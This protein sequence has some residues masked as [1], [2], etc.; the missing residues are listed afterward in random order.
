M[1]REMKRTHPEAFVF[2]GGVTSSYFAQEILAEFPFIDA[3]VLGHGEGVVRQLLATLATGGDPKEV[4]N[5]ALNIDGEAIETRGIPFAPG[6]LPD[7]NELPKPPLIIIFK[8]FGNK[9]FGTKFGTA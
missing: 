6:V 8:N 9:D 1:A 5:L 3:V 7:M 4:P 2:L